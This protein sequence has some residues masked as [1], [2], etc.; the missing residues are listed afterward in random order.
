MQAAMDAG[1]GVLSDGK[2]EKAIYTVSTHEMSSRR[3]HLICGGTVMKAISL[4]VGIGIL[5]WGG[6]FL[7]LG[8]L[9]GAL[10]AMVVFGNRH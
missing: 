7:L 5:L 10:A 4:V 6:V 3:V 9:P 2:D 8:L 1:S